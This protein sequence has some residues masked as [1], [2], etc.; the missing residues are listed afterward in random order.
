M[1]ATPFADANT[2]QVK[3]NLH[4]DLMTRNS[5]IINALAMIPEAVQIWGKD[6]AAS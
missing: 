1:T 6:T 4:L 5:Q 2:A 3:A